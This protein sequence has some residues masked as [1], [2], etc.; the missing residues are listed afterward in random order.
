M[1]TVALTVLALTIALLSLQKVTADTTCLAETH[2]GTVAKLEILTQG[3]MGSFRSAVLTITD[4]DGKLLYKETFQDPAQFAETGHRGK[5][6]VVFSALSEK[7]T[8]SMTFVGSNQDDVRPEQDLLKALRD[9]K[10]K[11][12][13]GNLFQ[14]QLHDQGNKRYEF[15]D[16]VCSIALD[17]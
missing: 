3:T 16:I 5:M 2:D 4:K 1:K 14:I 7:S 9:S 11:K 6:I 13:P 10:R 17:V 8:I 12:E 15:K